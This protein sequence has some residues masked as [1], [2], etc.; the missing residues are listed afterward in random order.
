MNGDPW[1]LLPHVISIF[2]STLYD[3]LKMTFVHIKAYKFKCFKGFIG[4]AC[5]GFLN[6]D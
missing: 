3:S 6:P 4:F 5:L 2:S 1:T